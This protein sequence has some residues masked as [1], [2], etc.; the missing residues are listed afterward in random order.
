[1][2]HSKRR[3]VVQRHHLDYQPGMKFDEKKGEVVKIYQS[4]HW[5]I[6]QMQRRTLI[7]KGFIRALRHWIDSLD[8]ND[9][10]DLDDLDVGA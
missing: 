1:M 4:E 6:T 5:V 8:E 3:F 9:L 10:D 7:S 2:G